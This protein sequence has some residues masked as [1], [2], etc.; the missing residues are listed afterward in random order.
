M[1]IYQTVDEGL[2]S[3]I[4]KEIVEATSYKDLIE[5]LK[6]R[7]YTYSNLSRMLNHI[8]CG[9]TK[10]LAIEC[11]EI[12]YIRVL[13]FNEVGQRYLGKIK[14]DLPLI[15]HCVTPSP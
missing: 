3:K 15:R 11:Q 7:R 5:K 10:E 13:G 9:F 8:L 14:K 4:K 6:S 2:S 12:E 1:S